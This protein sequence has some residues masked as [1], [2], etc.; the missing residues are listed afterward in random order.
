ME[1]PFECE[2]CHVYFYFIGQSKSH[3]QV[4]HQ[5]SGKVY[6]LMGGVEERES[7]LKNNTIEHTEHLQNEMEIGTLVLTQ[8][9][10]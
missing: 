4:R 3:K 9:S 7:S 1:A 2:G 8:A 5:W 10:L 6:S